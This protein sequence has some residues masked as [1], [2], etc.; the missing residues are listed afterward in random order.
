M[1]T[2]KVSNE[3]HQSFKFSCQNILEYHPKLQKNQWNP[4]SKIKKIWAVLNEILFWWYFGQKYSPYYPLS[5]KPTKLINSFSLL[6]PVTS[7]C[8]VL[9]LFQHVYQGYF[10]YI[11]QKDLCSIEDLTNILKIKFRWYSGVFLKKLKVNPFID[12]KSRNQVLFFL[13][14]S[15]P[16]VFFLKNWKFFTK[17]KIILKIKCIFFSKKFFFEKKY[18]L[19][20]DIVVWFWKKSFFVKPKWFQMVSY[21]SIWNH[22]ASWVVSSNFGGFF[23]FRKSFNP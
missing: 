12:S 10:Y 6:S 9:L 7:I 23:F 21:L 19:N 8:G 4:G 2:T 16:Y 18:F 22:L 14:Y 1:N 17:L 15:S 11:S 20:F 5:S 3:Y 13:L